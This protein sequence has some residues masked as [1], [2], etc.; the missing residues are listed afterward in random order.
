MEPTGYFTYSTVHKYFENF[1]IILYSIHYLVSTNQKV[2]I[3]FTFIYI[4][5]HMNKSAVGW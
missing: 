1:N 2:A 3:I 4:T 5:L